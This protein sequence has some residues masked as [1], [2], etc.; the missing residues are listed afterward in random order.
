MR[1][2]ILEPE[3]SCPLMSVSEASRQKDS[4]AVKRHSLELPVIWTKSGGQNSSPVKIIFSIILLVTRSTIVLVSPEEDRR[5]CQRHM[6]LL[7]FR[8]ILSTNLTYVYP[9]W[10]NPFRSNTA[11]QKS[12]FNQQISCSGIWHAVSIESK[13]IFDT[14]ITSMWDQRVHQLLNYIKLQQSRL[15]RLKQVPWVVTHLFYL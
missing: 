12:H 1:H 6:V 4:N 3:T 13:L 7:M 10:N 11:V 9:Y 2:L 5:R 14:V 8:I 15:C